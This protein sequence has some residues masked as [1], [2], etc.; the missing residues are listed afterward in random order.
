MRFRSVYQSFSVNR[1]GTTSLTGGGQGTAAGG[2]FS[3]TPDFDLFISWLESE[4]F[5][6]L[7]GWP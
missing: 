3:R 4:V 6:E 7:H 1:P 2:A 5:A